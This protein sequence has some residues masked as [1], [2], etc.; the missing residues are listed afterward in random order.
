MAFRFEHLEI[1][2]L[3]ID[4]G[5]KIHKL[6]KKFPKS[7]MFGLSSDLNRAAISISSNIAEGSGSESNREFKRYLRIAINSNFETI[8]NIITR[9]SFR[10]LP[11][12]YITNFSQFIF[13]PVVHFFLKYSHNV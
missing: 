3:A 11:H 5:E 1:W 2:K 7:E 6:I 4:Y 13:T 10:G 12:D 8:S 9:I